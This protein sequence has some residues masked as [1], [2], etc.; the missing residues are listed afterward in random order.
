MPEVRRCGNS[1]AQC[2]MAAMSVVGFASRTDAGYL[3]D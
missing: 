3:T 1:G 2:T